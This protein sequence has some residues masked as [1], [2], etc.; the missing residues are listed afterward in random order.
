MTNF[1]RALSQ[2]AE[3]QERINRVL[4]QTRYEKD[5]IITVAE[6]WLEAWSIDMDLLYRSMHLR[7]EAAINNIAV[8]QVYWMA[9]YT[10]IDLD[11]F[12]HDEWISLMD[13]ASICRNQ[14]GN[15]YTILNE[16]EKSQ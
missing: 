15:V 9:Y 7:Q 10:C 1:F 11:A 12:E 6:Q 4:T 8:S 13:R 3:M 5:A 14:F 2:L 16:M